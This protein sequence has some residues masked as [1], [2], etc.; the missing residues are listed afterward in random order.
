MRFPFLFVLFK[1]LSK[2]Q[3]NLALR[4]VSYILLFCFCFQSFDKLI[5]ISYYEFNK[6]EITSLYCINKNKPKL[7]CEGKCHLIQKLNEEQKRENSPLHTQKGGFELQWFYS[8]QAQQNQFYTIF[9]TTIL[10]HYQQ[11]FT[12]HYKLKFFQPPQLLSI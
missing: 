7:H 2:L 4:I 10:F 11:K 8:I 6:T 5:T 1:I 3:E 9:L 12:R